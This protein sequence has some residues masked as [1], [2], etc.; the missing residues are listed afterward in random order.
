MEKIKLGNRE[1]MV[2][3]FQFSYTYAGLIF[4]RPNKAINEKIKSNHICSLNQKNCD[5]VFFTQDKDYIS[6]DV[7]QPIIY[8][9]FLESNSVNDEENEFDGSWIIVSW[10]GEEQINKS[11]KEIIEDGLSAFDWDKY[12]LNYQI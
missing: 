1:V 9:A 2:E 6:E 4:G 3:K 12:A 7:L 8:T 5:A 10:F 11:I